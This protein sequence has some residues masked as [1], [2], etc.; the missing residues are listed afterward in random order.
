MLGLYSLVWVLD[1]GSGPP[2]SPVRGHSWRRYWRPDPGREGVV[3]VLLPD[4][5]QG[6]HNYCG[7]VLHPG[8]IHGDTVH[9]YAG[10][11]TTRCF[12]VVYK[13]VQRSHTAMIMSPNLM[14]DCMF[15][16]LFSFYRPVFI[17]V[18]TMPHC[19]TPRRRAGACVN[20]RT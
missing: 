16:V 17:I 12:V 10:Y 19:V 18:T 8:N 9:H 1:C 14:R 13:I 20:R 3:R 4:L 15:I 2:C 6:R 11:V 7:L 5:V